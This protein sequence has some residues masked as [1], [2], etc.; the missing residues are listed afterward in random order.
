MKPSASLHHFLE[1]LIDYAGL[2]PPAKLEI[3][4]SLE[5]YLEIIQSADSWIVS[6]FIIPISSLHGIPA[7]LM[8]K[9]SEDFPLSL[10][11]ISADLCNEINTLDEFLNIYGNSVIFTGYE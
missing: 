9:Y 10:S 11:L 4:P 1:Q 3:R 6:Q 5:N 2:F 7:D 8:N